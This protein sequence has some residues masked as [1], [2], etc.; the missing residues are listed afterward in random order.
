M[1][2]NP[3]Y[4]TMRA[5]PESGGADFR[6]WFS[7]RSRPLGCDLGPAIIEITTRNV[8]VAGRQRGRAGAAC[9]TGR[10]SDRQPWHGPWG[11]VSGIGVWKTGLKSGGCPPGLPAGLQHGAGHHPATPRQHVVAPHSLV[12]DDVRHPP[13]AGQSFDILQGPAPYGTASRRL[14]P[15]PR[16]STP[17][18]AG[19]A[20]RA[21]RTRRWA[22]Q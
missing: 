20:R 14:T 9:G 22:H 3:V 18:A 16:G 4:K 12:G 2:A 13:A 10:R 6:S 21:G 7:Q 1:V 15:R 19:G 11:R 8:A 5:L 17:T